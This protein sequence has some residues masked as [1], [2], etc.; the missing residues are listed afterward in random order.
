MIGIDIARIKRWYAK[1]YP[2]FSGTGFDVEVTNAVQTAVD[3][4]HSF[5]GVSITFTVT[6]YNSET[7]QEVSGASKTVLYERMHYGGWK[8]SE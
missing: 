1:T 2:E 4:S 8:A 7:K 5:D 3:T 6:A